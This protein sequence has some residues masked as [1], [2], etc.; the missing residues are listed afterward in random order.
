MAEVLVDLLLEIMILE[1]A[2]EVLVEHFGELD[3]V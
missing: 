1:K 2:A 3:I